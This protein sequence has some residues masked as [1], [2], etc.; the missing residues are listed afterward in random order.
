MD[1]M[2]DYA[3]STQRITRNASLLT[4]DEAVQAGRALFDEMADFN[5]T[6]FSSRQVQIIDKAQEE[7]DRVNALY[8]SRTAEMNAVWDALY[9]ASALND[10]RTISTRMSALLNAGVPERDRADMEDA[11]AFVNSF[12]ADID[13]LN[14]I[15][16]NR[17]ELES[18]KNVLEN[19]Y[20]PD[21]S[22]FDLTPILHEVYER[23]ITSLN[24]LEQKWVEQH[25]Q[26]EMG[27]MSADALNAWKRQTAVLPSYLSMEM[28]AKVQTMIPLV[29]SELSRKRVAYITSLINELNAQEKEQVV[30]ALKKQG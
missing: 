3:Q 2:S 14:R 6:E 7:L 9:E 20:D 8:E 1:A 12:I 17:T 21:N 28:K 24:A 16:D 13:S 23:R 25:I 29:E 19:K 15:P 30:A 22:E 18:M 11:L 26:I 27:K 10:L 5:M 4:L